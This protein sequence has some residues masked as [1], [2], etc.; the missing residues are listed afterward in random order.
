MVVY[1]PFVSGGVLPHINSFLF[2]TKSI[3]DDQSQ[4]ATKVSDLEM[5]MEYIHAFIVVGRISFERNSDSSS[6][7]SDCQ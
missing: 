4:S 6:T 3:A 2:K 7:F 5:S 1:V